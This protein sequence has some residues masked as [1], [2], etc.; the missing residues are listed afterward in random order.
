M[1]QRCS[2]AFAD[3]WSSH[4]TRQHIQYYTC[5]MGYATKRSLRVTRCCGQAV[6]GAA[7]SSDGIS[8]DESITNLVLVRFWVGVKQQQR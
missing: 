5:F 7:T 3:V 4:A 1:L 8:N 2:S 6:M